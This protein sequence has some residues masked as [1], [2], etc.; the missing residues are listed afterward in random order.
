MIRIITAVHHRLT[1]RGQ[2]LGR[3]AFFAAVGGTVLMRSVVQQIAGT[4]WTPGTKTLDFV[5]LRTQNNVI[6][7]CYYTFTLFG[8]MKQ[9]LSRWIGF[10]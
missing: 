2:I 1:P 9:Q 6:L 3:I 8:E 10:S 4:V 7:W 5:V